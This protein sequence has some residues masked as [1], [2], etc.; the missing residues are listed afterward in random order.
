MQ[1]AYPYIELGM[2]QLVL[3]SRESKCR[4]R[5]LQLAVR[6][7][8]PVRTLMLLLKKPAQA[9]NS[10]ILAPSQSTSTGASWQIEWG[11]LWM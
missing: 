5:V 7:F 8:V 9:Q 1:D 10:P 4:L 6:P 3:I 2:Q 11:S